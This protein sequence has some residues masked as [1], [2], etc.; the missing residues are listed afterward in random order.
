MP[1]QTVKT[2]LDKNRIK[3][4]IIKHSLAFTAQEIAAS[5]H[6]KGKEL[7]KTILIKIDGKM[8]MAVLPAS[9]KIDLDLLKKYVSCSNCRL[10]NET[11]FKDKFPECEVGAMPPFGN[12]FNM[13]VFVAESITKSEF[14]AF[15][16]CSHIE[17]MQMKYK[18]F[19][20]LVKPRVLKFSYQTKL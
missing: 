6:I 8:I 17:L 15:N 13:E 16:A 7:A 3:Y 5:A 9:Y 19:E 10:A 18:D 1:S 12:L 2:F 20:K 14:I 11:E 4:V